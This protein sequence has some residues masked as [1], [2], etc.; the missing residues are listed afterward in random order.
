MEMVGCGGSGDVGR[1]GDS[2]V[3][4]IGRGGSAA[5]EASAAANDTEAA[6]FARDRPP[7]CD[8]VPPPRV[9]VLTLGTLLRTLG[10][11]GTLRTLAASALARPPL[12]VTV[13]LSALSALSG[14]RIRGMESVAI[15]SWPEMMSGAEI[16]LSVMGLIFCVWF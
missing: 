6:E 11:L 9:T 12:A 8:S 1:G 4:L 14:M 13:A 15:R 10:T 5:P 3:G 16:A 2:S 7:A